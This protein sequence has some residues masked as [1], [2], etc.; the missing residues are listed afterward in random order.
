MTEPRATEARQVTTS[1]P[2]TMPSIADARRALARHGDREH[3]R[4]VILH[5]ETMAEADD[6]DESVR[7]RGPRF[8][9]HDV[10]DTIDG[11]DIIGDHE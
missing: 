1:G 9:L 3:F 8:T 7:S 2:A 11:V 5:F 10:I 6:F 4:V